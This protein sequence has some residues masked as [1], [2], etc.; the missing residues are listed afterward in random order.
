MWWRSSRSMSA[1][2]ESC[3]MM[4]RRSVVPPMPSEV[5]SAREVAERWSIPSAA[6]SA[7]SLGSSMRMVGGMLRAEKDHQLVAGAADVAGA[8][9][10]DGVAGFGVFQKKFD[11][12]LH[13]AD[14]VNVFVA[15]FANG[16]SKSFARNAGNGR[17]A[18]RVD[19][20]EN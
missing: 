17:V 2:I 1:G 19:V 11:G 14:V 7:M 3:L 18:G 8:D 10:K 9:G 12:I 6:S 5:S 4:R 20:S 13:G 16:G 15:G